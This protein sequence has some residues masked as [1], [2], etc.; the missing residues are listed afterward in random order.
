MRKRLRNM[1]NF[2][3]GQGNTTTYRDFCL[4]QAAREGEHSKNCLGSRF[5]PIGEL[6]D[7]IISVN[8]NFIKKLFPVFSSL[9]RVFWSIQPWLTLSQFGFFF[10]FFSVCLSFVLLLYLCR[11]SFLLVG[12]FGPFFFSFFFLPPLLRQRRSWR[13]LKSRHSSP[14]GPWA[15]PLCLSKPQHVAIRY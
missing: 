14:I 3:Q 15:W 1:R 10:S 8:E 4:I 13:D 2:C 5:L 9:I 12:F 11:R 7:A 6:R